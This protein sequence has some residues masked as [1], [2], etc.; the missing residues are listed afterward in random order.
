MNWESSLRFLL[1]VSISLMVNG[2]YSSTLNST[3]FE[4]DPSKVKQISWKP[5]SDFLLFFSSFSVIYQSNW[6]WL[7]SINY[8]NIG[9]LY[10]WFQS[11]CVWR[12]SHW[13]RMWPF[14]NDC[15]SQFFCKYHQILIFHNHNHRVYN[16]SKRV[17]R[18]VFPW[19]SF[20]LQE[21]APLYCNV[22]S[23]FIVGACCIFKLTEE[24]SGWDENKE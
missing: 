24:M 21:I 9:G 22:K 8:L 11:V 16:I 3:Q 19:F 15:K 6:F 12:I 13:S 14:D 23:K 1:L 20:R 17:S 10:C 7:S 18:W 5:R 2:S 4:I